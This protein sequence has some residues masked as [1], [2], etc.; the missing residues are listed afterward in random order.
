MER[1]V[2]FDKYFVIYGYNAGAMVYITKQ[3]S[4]VTPANSFLFKLVQYMARDIHLYELKTDLLSP[5]INIINS[6]IR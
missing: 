1:N 5:L 2:S 3:I 6:R 4:Q